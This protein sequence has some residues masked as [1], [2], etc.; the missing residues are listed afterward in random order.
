[1]LLNCY[2]D[3]T[4]F[5][6]EDIYKMKQDN[7]PIK[8]EEFRQLLGVEKWMEL[9]TSGDKER[10]SQEYGNLQEAINDLKS[11]V[12]LIYSGTLIKKFKPKS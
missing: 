12:L 7:I 9:F 5:Q 6:A 4:Y 10:L 2:N 11:E 1:M 8:D 3:I